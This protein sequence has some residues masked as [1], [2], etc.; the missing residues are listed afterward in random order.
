MSIRMI[1]KVGVR[2]RLEMCLPVEHYGMVVTVR[3]GRV[4]YHG[5]V[6]SLGDD[7][8]YCLE[9]EQESRAISGYIVREIETGVV[10]VFVDETSDSILSYK[11]EGSP[12]EVLFVLFN[13][14]VMGGVSTLDDV[15]IRVSEIVPRD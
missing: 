9:V 5:D 13:F 12:Y 11:F 4:I 10:S 15:D 3:R 14:S 8:E 6:I 2:D 1:T 7:F